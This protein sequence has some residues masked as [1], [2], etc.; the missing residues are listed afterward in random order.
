MKIK[1][2]FFLGM[3]L[4]S[5]IVPLYVQAFSTSGNESVN[6]SADTLLKPVANV[7]GRTGINSSQLMGDTGFSLSG[8][9][10]PANGRSPYNPGPKIIPLKTGYSFS[11]S[12]NPEPLQT[13]YRSPVPLQIKEML[14]DKN[15]LT[16]NQ[17]KLTTSLL[18]A[19]GSSTPAAFD[20]LPEVQLSLI[21]R[22]YTRQ[23]SSSGTTNNLSGELVYVYIHLNPGN[24]THCIDA[25]V[26]EVTGRDEEHNLAVAWVD[27]Y[28]LGEVAS[29]GCVRS[30]N[31]VIPP[32]VNAGTALTEGD[33][34]HNT[35]NVRSLYGYTG[36]GIKIGVI[37]DGVTSLAKSVNCGDLPGNV[38]VLSAG[39][40]DEGTAMLEIIHDMVPDATLYFHDAG[41][42]TVQFNAAID[43]LQSRGCTVIVD[44]I[45]WVSEPFFEDG[46]IASH[47]SSLVNNPANPLVYVSA[48]GNTARHHYQGDFFPDGTTNFTDFS[49]GSGPVKSLNV[50]LPVQSTV[51]IILEWNDRFGHS[52]NDY[53]LFLSESQSGDLAR[54]V[55]TQSGTQDPVEFIAYKNN[56]I[57]TKTAKIDVSKYNGDTRTLE[58]YIYPFYGAFVYPD[59]I[60]A[61]DSIFGH[62]AVP[63]VIS[64]GAVYWGTPTV[65]E[66]FSSRGPVT[67]SY[68]SPVI[69]HKPD[70][71]GVDGVS[72]SG[73]GGF[74]SPFYGTSAAAPHVAAVA[75]QIWGEHPLLSPQD[76]RKA[77]YNSGVDLGLPGSDTTFGF[78]RADALGMAN[79][80]NIT[81]PV[82]VPV[83]NFTAT[84]T[85]G[86]A[87][88]TVAFNDFSTN[89]PT[90]WNWSFGDGSIVNAT[91][92]NPV[93][94]YA[95]SG[96]Y[97]VSLNVSNAG[98]A[99]MLTRVGYIYVTNGTTGIGVFRP[100]THSFYLDFNGNGIWNGTAI[101][102]AYNFG[103]STDLPVSGDW[104]NDGITEMGVFRPS[105]QS[106]YLDFN[107][108]G[109]W[110][111]AVIDRAYNF[112]I[113]TDLPVS[114]DWN[115]DGI[116]E[117]GVFR[118]STQSFY[119]DFNGNG[120]WNGTA[121]DRAYNFGI[122]TDLPVS[123][124]WNN[125][126]ITEIGV[127]RPS[128][129]SFY[130]DFNGN[131]IWNGTAI[132]RA[133]NFGISTDLPI[134]G[135][136][137]NDGITEIGV[138]R[139]S[140]QSF[141]LDFNGNG[142]WN[143]TAIDRLYNFGVTE[144]NPVAG[145]WS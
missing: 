120:I 141:Y 59:N 20:T 15:N 14:I 139:P 3:I 9:N 57:S 23:F 130:L 143:G 90:E 62:P 10:P 96:N 107:G 123:G 117:I 22:N 110:N 60:V 58:L 49:R 35:V 106:F 18:L 109:I 132:D 28:R 144:D 80:V 105:T 1:D 41:W 95:A 83:A 50:N 34:I 27:R 26:Y 134:S 87:P 116:T 46:E 78:G 111:G 33:T 77:L 16:A 5:L 94:T 119:L 125:D 64:T 53:D 70:I 79:D 93:H 36:A 19:S 140:T 108:N 8:I 6:Q 40:G 85:M 92:Q 72:V 31:E 122:S 25:Y 89:M 97:T 71:T 52:A 48:A 12:M 17:K 136:W 100:S 81:N 67:I 91:L 44:D 142:I 39:S 42:D 103:I 74:P 73:A 114:G 56:G 47:V 30:I 112:G 68:P 32:V 43:A 99:D 115:N 113:S 21:I 128:T 138:F 126:G 86:T 88:L 38:N 124:D 145:K 69:R 101:D 66:P 29:T 137:N 121:I 54:S 131:G 51:W 82:P 55:D 61:A 75:A 37:S 45:S 98:G 104:N 84:P 135:D 76:I 133:Y 118:P 24:S 102:R 127:F 65:I 129:Q 13:T 4:V 63:G 7:T 2:K 11:P